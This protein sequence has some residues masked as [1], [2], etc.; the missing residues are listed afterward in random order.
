MATVL[1]VVVLLGAAAI[2]G[3]GIY[4]SIT[5]KP[6]G[7]WLIVCGAITMALGL[8]L[9]LI[10]LVAL[11]QE[12]NTHRMYDALLDLL[13]AAHWMRAPVQSIADD[14]KISDAARSLTHREQE[15][16]ALRSAI[17]DEVRRANWELATQLVNQM[18]ER[19]G[20][21]EEAVRL[22]QEIAETRE[23]AIETKIEEALV[24]ID[25]LME[26]TDWETA[27]KESERLARIFPTDERV[28]ELPERIHQRRERHK[29]EL[30]IE[31]EEVVNRKE[32]DRAIQ[33]LHELDQYLTPTE[34]TELR[35]SARTVLK[36][37]LV[38]L[39][40]QFKLAV[41]DRRWRDAL[42][43]GLE[44]IEERPN[45]KM[46]AEVRSMLVKLQERAGITTEAVVIDQR[47]G[48]SEA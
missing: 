28:K 39:G 4:H 11:K 42:E 38:N 31:W 30:L 7:L 12:A 10:A 41:S 2:V 34:A 1:L 15:C 19:F 9:F 46:A 3:L 29:R 21:H 6:D 45:S 20:Y 14:V 35:E 40:V 48:R 33:I 13:E 36:D 32:V 8:F 44:I 37:K 17:Q 5:D 25:E 26:A 16:A 24:R 43:V 22:R 23:M 27:T 47:R 18:E